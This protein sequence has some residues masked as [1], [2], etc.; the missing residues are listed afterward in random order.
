LKTAF[1]ADQRQPG[2]DPN[3][4]KKVQSR[5]GPGNNTGSAMPGD[6]QAPLQYTKL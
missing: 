2:A 5:D 1:I 6:Q 4:T 3:R